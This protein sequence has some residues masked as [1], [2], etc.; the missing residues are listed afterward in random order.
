MPNTATRTGILSSYPINAAG[1]TWFTLLILAGIPIFWIG[2]VSMGAAWQTAEYSHGPLIPIISLYLFIRELRKAPMPAD[3]VTDRWPGVALLAFSL[4]I[5]VLGNMMRIADVT[6]Y[7]LIFWVG[8]VVL[9]VFGW[10]RG[11]THWAP[12]LHLVFMLPLP[13][14]VYWKLTIFLQ[15]VSSELG[16]WFVALA[17]VPVFLE[18]NVID[19]GVY[20]LQVAEACSGLRYLFPILSFS[21]LFSILYKGPMWHK[22]VLLLSAAPLTSNTP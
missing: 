16:V 9:T 8:G 7:A 1:L 13:Q 12:V 18:G 14:F 15:G 22:A 19:L 17:G 10:K 4:I 20:K 3:N 11:K 5:A 21:Y 6:T 2:L